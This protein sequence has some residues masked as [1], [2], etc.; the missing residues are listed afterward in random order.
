MYIDCMY[1]VQRMGLAYGTETKIM[2][3]VVVWIWEIG[4][5]GKKKTKKDLNQFWKKRLDFHL[6]VILEE[7]KSGLKFEIS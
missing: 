1:G 3:R 4:L 2:T 5:V 7:R 6:K